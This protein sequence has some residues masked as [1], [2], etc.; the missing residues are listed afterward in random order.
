MKKTTFITSLVI[1]LLGL[2]FTN[3]Q[4]T[5]FI[6]PANTYAV[7]SEAGT[8]TDI[9][10]KPETIKL[11]ENLATGTDLENGFFIDDAAKPFVTHK[12]DSAKTDP[13]FAL[14]FTFNLCGKPMTHF[15]ICASGGIFFSGNENV[16]QAQSAAWAPYFT[17]SQVK[18]LNLISTCIRNGSTIVYPKNISG[19]APVM[20]LIDGEEGAKTLTV[21][22]HYSVNG[23]AWTYQIKAHENGNIEFVMGDL[24]TAHAT[25]GKY[26]LFMA[27]V[28]NS[29]QI[30]RSQAVVVNDPFGADY[31]NLTSKYVHCLGITQ[32]AD[33]YAA[34]G[35]NS[36]S[37][38]TTVSAVAPRPIE[39]LYVGNNG[40]DKGHTLTLSVP[41]NCT[42]KAEKFKDEWYGFSTTSITATSFAGQIA[43]NKDKITTAEMRAAGTL[44][45]VLSTS[46]T[47]DY[48][49]ANGSW[50][51]NGDKP[52]ANS[53]VLLNA[54]PTFYVDT[55]GKTFTTL[56]A[57]TFSANGL[58]DATTYYI[59]I[60]A[61][62]FRCTGA[63]VYSDLC[64]TFSFT[65]SLDLPQTLSAGLPT[66]GSVPLTVKPAEGLGMV[67]LKSPNVNGLKLSGKLKAGDKIGEAE[68]L[69]VL[70]TANETAFNAPF[71]AGEGAYILAYSVKNPDA[72][73]PVY[74]Q[75]FLS[76][77]VRAAYDTLPKFRFNGEPCTFPRPNEFGRLPFGWSRET[78]F[79]ANQRSN[80]FKL[81]LIEP[82]SA[83]SY[84]CLSSS[85]PG[86]GTY[87]SDVVTAAFALP[88]G[89][90]KISTTFFLAFQEG[91]SGALEPGPH[92]M[93][94]KD[95][96]RIEYSVNGG[97]WQTAL[98]MDGLSDDF[99]QLN[100][101]KQYPLN[102]LIR[103]LTPGSILRLRYSFRA[104]KPDASVSCQ[105]LAVDI[106]EG[107]D[108]LAPKTLQPVDS[109]TTNERLTVHWMDENPASNFLLAYQT[110][111][112]AWQY[113][114]I[115]AGSNRDIDE[116][117]AGEI[118]GLNA[119]TVYN[120][121]VASLCSSRDTSFYTEP[122][123]VRTAYDL[124]YEESMAKTG[125]GASAQTPF[126]RGVKTYSGVI[127]RQL[128]ETT[129][130]LPDWN[131]LKTSAPDNAANAVSVADFSTG[132]WLMLPAIYIRS[133]GGLMPKSLN[134]TLNSF[135][136]AK[137]KGAKPTYKDTELKVLVSG[138]GLFTEDNIV[139]KLDFDNLALNEQA[140]MID[141]AE[142]K[143][144][145]QIAFVFECPT[146]KLN[147]QTDE[148][149]WYLE[150]KD[151]VVKY[152][153][154]ICFPVENLDRS[155]GTHEVPLTWNKSASAVEY[156]IFWGVYSGEGEGYSDSAFTTETHY[157][158]TGLQDNTRYKAMVI[159]YCNEDHSFASTPETTSFRT[160][161][162]CHTPESFH[163]A[164]V[165]ATGADFVSTSDQPDY[166][167][168]RI[169]YIT[170]D[171]GDKTFAFIQDADTLHVRDSLTKLTAYTATTQAVCEV[172]TSA[173]SEEIHFTTT[174]SLATE[175]IAQLNGLFSVRAQDGQ[176]AIR[177]L[178]N[179]LIRN[180]T[181]FNQNGTKLAD[182][183]TDSRDDLL[184]PVGARRMLIFVRL[185]TERG[186]A[187]YK[188][189][190]Y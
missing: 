168:Q 120:I 4:T 175:R 155:M 94:A 26:R 97:A 30:V 82:M 169:V 78:E 76:L 149:H 57:Q 143:D 42:P 24:A 103:N 71:K 174:D 7:T 163:V 67:L 17:E 56:N 54:K 81:G 37:T 139:K 173:M 49:L 184:L 41:E 99:P 44:V 52:S 74:G 60:Y 111:A 116:P 61:M 157:T 172:D 51:R 66:T 113:K 105:I 178:N 114:R 188:T 33:N 170:A 92:D 145:L 63:P 36:V 123:R 72:E 186:V 141:L 181:V 129:E 73:S 28:E 156:G 3:A 124:P 40:P 142:C 19:Q 135:D 131:Q 158:I 69:T 39:G 75:D 166:M 53:Q 161:R 89:I 50:Y 127:G 177:N 122:L 45:A 5:D 101:Q 151:V 138:N 118:S 2:N 21:Q 80:A 86:D 159:A 137:T 147:A 100:A 88:A 13:G 165:F 146:G 98:K 93:T 176:I 95:S 140:F 59:H 14:G 87:W 11:G 62:E 9:A 23:D 117:V 115:S 10:D 31:M 91:T 128:T 125:S 152:D 167:T 47:P 43:F 20:Y 136:D 189:I 18:Y 12:A 108:C 164:D 107:K 48:T 179:L 65:S 104:P 84:T 16:I 185:Q 68:V 35:W 162:A 83:P 150:I 182:F 32:T 38:Y 183:R 180:V 22:Y 153:V 130:T 85:Y 148:D 6:I 64:R 126:D 8:F 154:D 29:G 15:T 27:F 121:K 77:P 46:E 90:D 187:I 133:I 1:C 110:G 171:N 134:F 70:T 25:D 55:D 106:V 132:A 109:L 79:P 34:E 96:V 102:A 58:T 160:S 144:F 112:D 119:G 190:L